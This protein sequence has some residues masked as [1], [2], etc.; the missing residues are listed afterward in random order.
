MI[1]VLRNWFTGGGVPQS[2]A[3]SPANEV[4]KHLAARE[5]E[6]DVKVGGISE[7]W[8]EPAAAR[9]DNLWP[10]PDLLL[11]V[12]SHVKSSCA[13]LPDRLAASG[14]ELVQ[15]HARM[16]HRRTDCF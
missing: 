3:R 10:G 2:T 13:D 16:L 11:V 1:H 12:S 4:R 15:E 6:E 5:F 9:W 8:S 7:G 14:R